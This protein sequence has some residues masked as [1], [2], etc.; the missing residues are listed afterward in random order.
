MSAMKRKAAHGG[1]LR[2]NERKVAAMKTERSIIPITVEELHEDQ[3]DCQLVVGVMLRDFGPWKKGERHCLTFDF[4]HGEVKEFD[5]EG[6]VI[7]EVTFEIMV[8]NE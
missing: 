2:P 6:A 4:I 7:A 5:D 3:I 1:R 8:T